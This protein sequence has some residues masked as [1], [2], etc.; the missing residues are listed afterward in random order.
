MA[1][2]AA[3]ETLRI[4]TFHSGL[5]RKGPGT[6]VRDLMSGRDDQAEAV[7]DVIARAAPDVLLLLDVDWDHGGV[8]LDTLVERLAEHGVDYPYRVAPQPNTGRPSGFDLDGNGRSDEARDALGYGRFSG[9]GGLVILA[10]VP[11]GEVTDHGPLWIDAS[12]VADDLLPEGAGAVMPLATVGQ[13][14]VPVAGMTLI[15]MA[16][17]TPVFDG[18]EDRNGL[19]NRD[20][21]ALVARL[22][23]SADRPLVLGRANLDPEDGEGHRESVQALLDH[24]ALQDPAPRGAGGGGNGHRGDPALDTVNWSGPGPLRVDYVLPPRDVEV[25]ASGVVWPAPDDPFRE[26]VEASG[27]GRLVWVDIALP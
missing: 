18:P 25:V 4:A 26:V 11:L 9:D 5:S 24:P 21:L 27:T 13:W 7:Q 10:R 3:A 19:R 12:D 16:A 8:A 22:A 6:L 17:G 20:E 23:A 2:P 1:A 15:P 14:S